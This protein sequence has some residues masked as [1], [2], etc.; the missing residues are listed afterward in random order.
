LKKIFRILKLT[1]CYWNY[2]K[3]NISLTLGLK[4]TKSCPKIPFIKVFFQGGSKS[5]PKFFKKIN[6]DFIQFSMTKLFNIHITLENISLH[7]IKTPRLVHTLLIK[8]ISNS[9]KNVRG[10]GRGRGG[11][12]FGRSQHEKQMKQAT[13]LN[14][15]IDYVGATINK[16]SPKLWPQVGREFSTHVSTLWSLLYFELILK[17]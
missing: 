15:L 6:F 5:C 16:P 1:S 8:R 11:P 9:T 12:W 4:I 7:I 13:I 10:E 3:F 14:R 2:S 17:T